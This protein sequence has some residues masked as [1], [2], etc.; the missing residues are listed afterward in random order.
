MPEVDLRPFLLVEIGRVE[1]FHFTMEASLKDQ[2]PE[3]TPGLWELA[4]LASLSVA[5][6]QVGTV[7]SPP[8]SVAQINHR[9]TCLASS[10]VMKWDFITEKL[11]EKASP[12]SPRRVDYALRA[13]KVQLALHFRIHRLPPARAAF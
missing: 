13:L 11:N 8:S 9:R 5:V 2:T 1:T 12:S 10:N 7:W 6:S 3:Q 4:G